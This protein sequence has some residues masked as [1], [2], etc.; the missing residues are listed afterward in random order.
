M[1]TQIFLSEIISMAENGG[2]GTHFLISQILNGLTHCAMLG[3]VC[4]NLKNVTHLPTLEICAE[5]DIINVLDEPSRDLRV[6]N[7]SFYYQ[8]NS[9]A[10]VLTYVLVLPLPYHCFIPSTCPRAGKPKVQ[11]LGK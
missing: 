1:F 9:W 5:K 6:E 2:Q 3:S 4:S 11:C 8:Y 7:S 10:Q